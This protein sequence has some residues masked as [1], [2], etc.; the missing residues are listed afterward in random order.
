MCLLSGNRSLFLPSVAQLDLPVQTLQPMQTRHSPSHMSGSPNESNEPLTSLLLECGSCLRQKI[1]SSRNILIPGFGNRI[2]RVLFHCTPVE[3]SL[4]GGIPST[5]GATRWK[6]S[7]TLLSDRPDPSPHQH[8]FSP[9]LQV[10][11]VIG[12]NHRKGSGNSSESISDAA[13]TRGNVN[14][15]V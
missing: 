14:L 15:S 5:F 12:V 13:T 2:Y 4:L 6:G 8:L 10:R 7:V 1:R 11:V 3:C 9:L